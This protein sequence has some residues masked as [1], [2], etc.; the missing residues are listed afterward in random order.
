MRNIYAFSMTVSLAT[1]LWI[2]YHMLQGLTHVEILI[3]GMFVFDRVG[4]GGVYI[5]TYVYV[6]IHIYIYIN[7]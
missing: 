6:H 5:H 2:N 1:G 4:G 3:V 7:M